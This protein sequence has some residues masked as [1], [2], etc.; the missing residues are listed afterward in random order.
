VSVSLKQLG[1]K[2]M[3]LRISLVDICQTKTIKRKNFFIEGLFLVIFEYCGFLWTLLN[4]H[5]C[6]QNEND[7]LVKTSLFIEISANFYNLYTNVLYMNRQLT[8]TLKK[9]NMHSKI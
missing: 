3:M 1:P 7:G 5:C 8:V 4:K 6:V 9:L 2:F